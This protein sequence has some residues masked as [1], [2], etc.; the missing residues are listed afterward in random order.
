MIDN[1][2][3]ALKYE[4]KHVRRIARNREDTI[5]D[6]EDAIVD[7]CKKIDQL[8]K[9]SNKIAEKPNDSDT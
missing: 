1:S 9:H 7:L 2:Y 4:L 8:T 6:R 3:A 5:L